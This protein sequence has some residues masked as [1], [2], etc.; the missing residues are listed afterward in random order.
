MMGLREGEVLGLRWSDLDLDART[1]RVA[2]ALQRV[3]GE[4][5]FKGAEVR[6]RAD[7]RFVFLMR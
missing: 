3:D 4:L 2:Q 1:L 7:E 5:I 6:P